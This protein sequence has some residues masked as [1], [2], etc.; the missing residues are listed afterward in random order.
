RAVLPQ[1]F[2]TARRFCAP[3]ERAESPLAAP[4]RAGAADPAVEDAAAVEVHRTSQA[5]HEVAQLAAGLLR[6]DLVNDLVGDGHQG[7]RLVRQGRFG[8]EN[9]RLAILQAIDDFSGGLSSR[10]L[11]EVLLDVL[12]LQGA[13]FE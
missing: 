13:S 11:A 8:H 6:A 10:K 2:H 3:G 5:A 9:E 12:D 1:A 7:A 4:V